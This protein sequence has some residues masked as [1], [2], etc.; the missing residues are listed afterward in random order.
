MAEMPSNINVAFTIKPMSWEQ[1]IFMQF[2]ILFAGVSL[3]KG[4]T[5]NVIR[6]RLQETTLK[7]KG[8]TSKSEIKVKNPFKI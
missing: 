4:R 7:R 1:Q 2:K 3:L 8:K 5:F 6:I